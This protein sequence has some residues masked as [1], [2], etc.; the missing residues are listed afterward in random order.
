MFSNA[1]MLC[2]LMVKISFFT[3]M[4]DIRNLPL[5]TQLGI[6]AWLPKS[7]HLCETGDIFLR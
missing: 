1:D 5:A 3:D 6:A 2:R 4:L 7:I